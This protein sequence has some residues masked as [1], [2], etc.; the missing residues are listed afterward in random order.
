M[1]IR[2]L[3]AILAIFAFGVIV[4]HNTNIYAGRYNGGITVGS[5]GFELYGAT[6]FFRTEGK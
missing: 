3:L 4:G 6:G 5:V 2:A 1:K